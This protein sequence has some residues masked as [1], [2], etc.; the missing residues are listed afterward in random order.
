MDDEHAAAEK[1]LQVETRDAHVRAAHE[2]QRTFQEGVDTGA[3]RRAWRSKQLLAPSRGKGNNKWA[4]VR[5]PKASYGRSESGPAEQQNAGA[6]PT[7]DVAWR[8]TKEDKT[9]VR[10]ARW[11]FLPSPC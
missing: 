1:R 3:G 7:R 5:L 10:D 8:V 4:D 2:N 11:P 6:D 9:L